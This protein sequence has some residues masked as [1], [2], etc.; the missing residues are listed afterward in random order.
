MG[1]LEDAIREHLDLKRK[2]GA[3]EVEVE[4]QEVE[5]LGPARREVAPPEPDAEAAPQDDAEYDEPLAEAAAVAEEPAF[6][7]PVEPATESGTPFD[8]VEEPLADASVVEAHAPAEG[9]AIAESPSLDDPPVAEVEEAPHA[10]DPVVAETAAVEPAPVVDPPVVEPPVEDAPIENDRDPILDQPTEFFDVEEDAG[11][12]TPPQG[13]PAQQEQEPEDEPL[14][15]DEVEAEDG[16]LLE[17]TPDFLQD[18]PEHDRLWFEQKP[19]RD[20]DFD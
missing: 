15:D 5:A 3:S 18:A 14:E 2:H 13:F 19:P 8:E 1:V 11:G 9:P 20:F 10:E 7:T 12:D 6:E 17:D 16:D 4:R